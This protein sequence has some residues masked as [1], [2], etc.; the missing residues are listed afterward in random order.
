MNID[1]CSVCLTYTEA[2]CVAGERCKGTYAYHMPDVR[3]ELVVPGFDGIIGMDDIS[4][5]TAMQV[6]ALMLYLVQRAAYL[7]R[8]DGTIE[9]D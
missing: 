8:D 5:W 7:R 2:R 9:R 1:L 6:R 3:A 4:T